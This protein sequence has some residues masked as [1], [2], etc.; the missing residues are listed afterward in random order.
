MQPTF[1]R[2]IALPSSGLKNISASKQVAEHGVGRSSGACH[3][4]VCT[5]TH[6]LHFCENKFYYFYI[7]LQ[8]DFVF[9]SEK[10][11]KLSMT[12]HRHELW[13]LLLPTH[14]LP[15]PCHWFT[16]CFL[17][18]FSSALKMEAI[19]SS[20]TSVASQQTTRRHIPENDT[21]Y[22]YLVTSQLLCHVPLSFITSHIIKWIV[23]QRKYMILNNIDS[24]C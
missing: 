18:K 1:Q 19:C 12:L 11:Q 2:N 23:M 13:P 8:C 5:F 6:H 14:A 9:S 22:N 7:L 21:L 10:C 15:P 3:R 16:C 17:L 24:T 4:T 20:E